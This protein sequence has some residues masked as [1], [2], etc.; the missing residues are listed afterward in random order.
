MP[1]NDGYPTEEELVKITNWPMKSLNDY[2]DLMDYIFK[3]WDYNEYA[4]NRT[5]NIYQIS[6][7]GWSG[8]EQIIYAMQQ[9]QMFWLF[10]WGQSTR[11]GHYIFAPMN[12]DI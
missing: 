7:M 2:H 10:Y 6:T 8:N 11:G 3:L 1:D 12:E 9:N 5:G 4:W